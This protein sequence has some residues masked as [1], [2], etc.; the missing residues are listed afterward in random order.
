M[1]KISIITTTFNA[2]STIK[3]TLDS[4]RKIKNKN[5]EYI[6]ID[7][8]SKDNTL[9]ILKENMDIIDFF[10]S[11]SDNGIYDAI[12]KGIKIATG[13]FTLFLAADD[14]IIPDAIDSF[15]KTIKDNTDVWSGAVIH[16]NQYGYFIEYSD[17]RLNKLENE[18]SLRHPASFFRKDIFKRYGL[19]DSTLKCSA[20]RE[21]FLRL[22]KKGAC[23]QIEDYPI[24]VFNDG[25]IS[26]AN[27]LDLP[28]KEGIII[29]K[30]YG[31]YNSSTDRLN[32][33]R[34]IR[35]LIKTSSFGQL[36]LK[37]F[38]SD[39]W[40]NPFNLLLYKFANKISMKTLNKIM[41]N[42]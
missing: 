17:R 18:C 13:D 35:Y 9:S 26:T 8:L 11:E 24:E 7:G 27:P 25:G 15:L 38:Y 37:I 32:K 16:H 23:F 12:N 21:I 34:K 10:I 5:I 30:K 20:D 3:N 29:E 2:E 39:L 28:I 1:F 36:L 42:D 40:I 33:K 22:Y 31:L 19:Y 4:V 6:V 14:Q 41:K